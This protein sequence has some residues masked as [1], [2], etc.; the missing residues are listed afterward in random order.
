MK[1]FIS[2]ILMLPVGLLWL[3]AYLAGP[4]FLIAALCGL[5]GGVHGR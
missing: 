2:M 4:L 3:A 5:Y 1:A